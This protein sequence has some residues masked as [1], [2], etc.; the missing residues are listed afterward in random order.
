M[1]KATAA[2]EKD[3]SFGAMLCTIIERECLRRENIYNA[4]AK[5]VGDETPLPPGRPLI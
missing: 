1:F 5:Y 3:P 2:A 4:G